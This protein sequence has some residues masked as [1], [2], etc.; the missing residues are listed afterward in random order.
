[1]DALRPLFSALARWSWSRAKAV[2]ENFF[3]CGIHR[4]QCCRVDTDQP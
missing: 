2:N 3:I 1:M 4:Q